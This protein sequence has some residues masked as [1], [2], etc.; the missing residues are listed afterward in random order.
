MK[1]SGAIGLLLAAA[2]ALGTGSCANAPP[3]GLTGARLVVTLRFNG[4]INDNY[5]YFFLIRNANDP[6]G[7]NGPIPVIQPP[8][9]NGFATGLQN[10]TTRP[11][12]VAGFTDFVEYSRVQRQVTASGYNVYHLPGGIKGDP[13]R[14]V[15]ETR[16]EPDFAV[17][18]NG[19]NMIQ[20][21]LLLDPAHTKIKPDAGE[22][23][24]NNGSQPRYLQV[25]VVATTTTPHNPQV[26][27]PAKFLDAFGDQHIGSGS[28]NNFITIDTT[29]VG[30]TYSSTNSP[31]DP[32]YE[33]D[34]DTYP[35]P[36]DPGIEMV[37]WA[38]QITSQ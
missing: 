31:G 4:P 36:S 34:N 3:A 33:P 26:V 35:G 22:I 8:Y 6:V 18:P 14:D 2:A 12:Y 21:E 19:G 1:A 37:N 20:F 9:L 7:Q 16:G 29:Q 17:P 32:F 5:Q 28:F 25:N 10:D 15:F 11:D 27:D 23:D 30:R 24:P 38:I 13:N